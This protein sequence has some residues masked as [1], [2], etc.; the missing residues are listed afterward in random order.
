M[1]QD[2][3]NNAAK[4]ALEIVQTKLEHIEKMHQ[5]LLPHII[6]EQEK[7]AGKEE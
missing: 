1:K 7:N 3:I 5:I 2:E 4:M 6:K